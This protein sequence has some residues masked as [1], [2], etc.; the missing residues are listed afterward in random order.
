MLVHHG[1]VERGDLGVV[2]GQAL[3]GRQFL[4]DGLG[5]VFRQLFENF[6]DAVRGAVG[7]DLHLGVGRTVDVVEEV[8]AGL[9]RLVHGGFVD[10]P[11][12]E[13]RR[14]EP[15]LLQHGLGRGCRGGGGDQGRTGH[16]ECRETHGMPLFVSLKKRK[17]PQ[18]G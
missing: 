8:V 3:R 6:V 18:L 9:H 1:V 11:G 4:D 14:V 10:A 7:R 2:A 16:Q 13:V 15:D 12:A 17:A 5:A